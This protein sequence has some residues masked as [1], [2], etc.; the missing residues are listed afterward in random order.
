[1]VIAVAG[2]FDP[3]VYSVI[4]DKLSDVCL[5]SYFKA[6]VSGI[7]KILY[8][9]RE[10]TFQVL[11]LVNIVMFYF[12]NWVFL[13][14][15]IFMMFKIRYIKDNLSLTLELQQVVCVWVVACIFE[16]AYYFMQ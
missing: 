8:I 11:S 12:V 6:N 4:P 2:M 1:M 7:D 10:K 14:A 9:S 15:L 16:Y 13:I 3:Y 5:C